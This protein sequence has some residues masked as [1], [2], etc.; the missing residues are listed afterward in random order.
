MMNENINIS[1]IEAYLDGIIKGKVS[2][3]VFAGTLPN[4]L[5]DDVKDLVLID[6]GN[7]INDLSS[8]GKGTLNVF[9][10]AKPTANGRKNVA[11]LSKMEKSMDGVIDETNDPRYTL[12]QLYKTTD[13]DSALNWHFVVVALNIIIS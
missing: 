13:Y 1:S 7:A 11:Q 10:Y 8:H 3:H 12:T 5:T 2:K 9:L 6:C 4:T